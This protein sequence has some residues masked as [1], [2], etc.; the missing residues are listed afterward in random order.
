L[1]AVKDTRLR[2][3]ASIALV[4]LG[5]QVIDQVVAFYNDP[6]KSR[7]IEVSENIMSFAT[8]RLSAKSSLEACL[9]DILT[10]LGWTP[11]PDEGQEREP[12]TT[13]SGQAKS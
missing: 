2:E 9:L 6:E 1:E 13:A 7:A 5:P 12:G 4:E 10:Q 11:P 3:K 8:N